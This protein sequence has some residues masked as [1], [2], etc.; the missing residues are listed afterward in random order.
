MRFTDR[1]FRVVKES[2]LSHVVARDQFI[3]LGYFGSPS[4]CTDRLRGLCRE[5]YLRV[6][7]TPYFAQYL[8]ATGPRAKEVVGARLASLLAARTPTPRHVQHCLAVTD[9]RCALLSAGAKRWRFE[10]QVHQA[11]GWLGQTHEVKPDGYVER[12]GL[13]TFLEIDLGHCGLPKFTDKLRSFAAFLRSGVFKETY[14]VERFEV[15]TV[16]MSAVRKARML[17]AAKLVGAPLSCALFE[18]L[19]VRTPGGWS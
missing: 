12:Q 15:L 8:Y 9:V 7:P 14:G 13:P 10:P 4:R 11:F 2:V 3:S 18:E 16:T 6:L 5:S 19:G 1:D 17:E